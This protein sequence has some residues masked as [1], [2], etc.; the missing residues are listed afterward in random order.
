M[1]LGLSASLELIS[2]DTGRKATYLITVIEACLILTMLDGIV[3]IQL[4][5]YF[6]INAG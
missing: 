1:R 5:R 6:L 3:N 4:K 2:I